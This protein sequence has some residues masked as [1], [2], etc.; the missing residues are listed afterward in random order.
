MSKLKIFKVLSASL[1]C[2][3]LQ[4][5]AET[6]Y[7]GRLTIESCR[8][9]YQ[10]PEGSYCD[11]NCAALRSFKGR[12]ICSPRAAGRC[13]VA[14]SSDGSSVYLQLSNGQTYSSA[15]KNPA[16]RGSSGLAITNLN[17]DGYH[18]TLHSYGGYASGYRYVFGRPVRLDLNMDHD[19]NGNLFTKYHCNLGR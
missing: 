14:Y 19:S 5:Q 2:F 8:E 10:V 16:F 3:C 13:S 12:A 11:R 6:W 15:L 4:A 7:S 9:S 1:F 17:L 18:G